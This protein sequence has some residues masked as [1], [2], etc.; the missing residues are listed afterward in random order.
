MEH[1]SPT[2]HQLLFYL[3]KRPIQSTAIRITPSFLGSMILLITC[4]SI[5]ILCYRALGRFFTFELTIRPKH[6]L[7]K[8]GPYAWVRHPGYTAMILG[9]V[10]SVLCA[11]GEGSW[12]RESGWLETRTGK[13]FSLFY[14][15]WYVHL[16]LGMVWRT[17]QEDKM[18]E[19]RFG[20]EWQ[21]WSRKVRY[22][23]VPGFY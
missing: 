6:E 16:A 7:V 12:M 17:G 22:K 2:A 9:Y 18:L 5:R 23:L 20:T 8:T 3:L 10:G 21:A 14:F 1:S 11:F 15:V 4:V 19:D 13:T